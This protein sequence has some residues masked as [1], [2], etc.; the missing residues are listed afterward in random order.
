MKKMDKN[1]N[2][3][4]TAAAIGSLKPGMKWL[5][6]E[7]EQAAGVAKRSK[8]TEAAQEKLVQSSAEI[9][10]KGPDP[11]N[12]TGTATG[13]VVG[14]VQSGKTLSFTTA[15]GLARDN[16]FPIV[17][18]IAG[19]KDNLL[20]QSHDRLVKDL[21]VNGGE[22]LPAWKMEKNPRAQDSQYEQLIRQAIENWQDPTR[23]P[24]EKSTLLLTVLKQ[25]HRLASLTELLRKM[26]L[27]NV[28]ALLIDDE[29]DQ[30]SL[31]TKVQRAEESTTY[32]RLRELR[33]ALPCHTFL[34]YTATPQAPLLINIA[35]NL[36]P[37]FVHV[38]EPGEGYVGGAAFFAPNS[39]YIKIIPPQDLL[40]TNALPTDPP[41]SLLEAMRVYYIGLAASLISKSGRRS[42]LIHPARERAAHQVAAGWA[43]AAKNE[44]A[45]ALGAGEND[46]DRVEVVRDFRA[47]YAELQNTENDLPSFDEI[48]QKLPR[49]LRNTTVIEFNTRGRPKTPEINWR[50]AEGWILVGGQAVDR[51][52]TV[53][54]LTV[55]YMPRGMGMGNADTLQQ[56]ARFFGYAGAR[57][58]FGVC[59]VYLEQSMRVAYEDYVEHEQLMRGELQRVAAKGESLRTWRRR[60]I[61]DPSLNPCRRSVIS[62]P[63]TRSS[64]GG[65]W[66]RQRGTIVDPD[67]RSANMDVLDTLLKGLDLKNDTSYPAKSAA[68]QH[69]VDPNVPLSKIIDALVDYRF[70]DPRD[71]AGFTGL[72]I[73]LAEGLRQDSNATAAVY[74]MRPSAS[75][76]REVMNDDGEIENF[77]QGRTATAGG[78]QSYPGDVSFVAG[79]KVSLQIHVYD[80]TLKKKP[81][82]RSAPLIT[83]HVPA[84][85]A[86]DWLVQ[87]Q[88][89]QQATS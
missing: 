15:I 60:F 72:L 13:L 53:D 22:G 74:R 64:V 81:F 52:F 66:T 30:A 21:D 8:L 11:R 89:G 73:T 58:Y 25:N 77:L 19:N 43:S 86:A 31:N 88:R 62:D 34:Q 54:S 20:T 27:Q 17:I 5:P 56:R 18:V 85:L 59:R 83:V 1:P 16:G 87:V 42:M 65:G 82:A 4:V 40:Q 41:E 39:P 79:D 50:H 7:G 67:G 14:Y 46:P 45:N 38:L 84:A 26:N 49:A 55:T 10:G 57:G 51:G 48:I 12:A 36:S 28:P 3:V 76:T 29:A 69:M 33:E 23:D 47:A 6:V 78:G 68:Q 61:L 37:D 35:D 44:W 75:G 32:R 24:D 9:L 80:L 70:E 63:Y 2:I 71:T